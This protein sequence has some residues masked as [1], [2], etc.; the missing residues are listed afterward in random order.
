[1]PGNTSKLQL[2]RGTLGQSS[3]E[4]RRP[5][6]F[7]LAHVVHRASFAHVPGPGLGFLE[8]AVVLLMPVNAGSG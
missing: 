3:L 1:M 6:R 8:V 4:S 5:A 7:A 2:F